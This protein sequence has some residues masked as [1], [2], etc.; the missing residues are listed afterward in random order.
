MLSAGFIYL[1]NFWQ[2]KNIEWIKCVALELESYLHLSSYHMSLMVVGSLNP[3]LIKLLCF[4]KWN[5]RSTHTHTQS[6]SISARLLWLLEFDWFHCI[7]SVLSPQEKSNLFPF[8]L[9]P[10]TYFTWQEFGIRVVW[11]LLRAH[12][13]NLVWI[14][15]ITLQNFSNNKWCE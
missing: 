3:H 15:I 11:I 5:L 14:S 13:L 2:L 9:C 7:L 6:V 8:R 10:P 12:C 4:F 1:F